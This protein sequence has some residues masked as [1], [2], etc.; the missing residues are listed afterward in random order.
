MLWMM[1]DA[2]QEPLRLCIDFAKRFDTMP[3]VEHAVTLARSVMSDCERILQRDDRDDE[4]DEDDEKRGTGWTEWWRAADKKGDLERLNLK[5]SR[6][7]QALQLALAAV[8]AAQGMSRIEKFYYI[9]GASASAELL[10]QQ[11]EQH[12][13][14]KGGWLLAES[15]VHEFL[16]PSGPSHRRRWVETYER[17]Q[18]SFAIY[19]ADWNTAYLIPIN[20]TRLLESIRCASLNNMYLQWACKEG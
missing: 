8:A 13:V 2:M 1:L 4:D 5:L 15:T 18:V 11:F 3:L 12:R 19:S 7:Q 10:L 20:N 6:A 16:V 17:C 9:P 14:N